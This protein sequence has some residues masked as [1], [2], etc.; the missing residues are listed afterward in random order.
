MQTIQTEQRRLFRVIKQRT[1]D[2]LN[3][4]S[5]TS[6]DDNSEDGRRQK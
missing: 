2:V 6:T 1:I 3:T 5:T 4:T